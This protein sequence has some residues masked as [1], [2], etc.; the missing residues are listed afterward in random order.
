MKVVFIGGGSFRTLPVVRGA[1]AERKIFHRGEICL[2]DLDITRAEAMGRMIMKTPEFTGTEC[3]VTW[4]KSL[5]ASLEG[6][7]AVSVVLMASKPLSYSLG[8]FIS[9]K[10]ELLGS[11]NVSVNGAFLALKGGRLITGIARKM[12]KLCPKAWLMIFANPVAVLSGAV[13]NY[14]KIKA[15]GICE[16]FQNHMWDLTRLMGRNEHCNEYDVDVAGVNHCS[17]ILRGKYR[18]R[19]LYKELEKHIAGGLKDRNWNKSKLLHFALELMIEMYYRFGVMIFSNETDGFYHL[20]PERT[21]A[22]TAG[23]R[24]RAEILLDIEKNAGAR[25]KAN[26]DF[27]KMLAKDLDKKFW[28]NAARKH[29]NQFGRHAND[30][31]VE[32]LKALAGAG[33]RKLVFSRP[34][35]GAV[36]GFKDNTVLEYSQMLDQNGCTPVPNLTIPDAL[37][38]ITSALA[39]HQTLLGDAI[40]TEDPKDLYQ[41]LFAYPLAH[42][43]KAYWSLCR[44]LLKINK[45]EIAASFQKTAD[46]FK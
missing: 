27:V 46:Y 8:C 20:Y 34:N 3:K 24:T 5:E 22:L 18:G 11:D 36:A 41:A 44:E 43:S 37:H 1:L 26:A 19:D 45:D 39:T 6:A 16:G 15:M 13:N 14:T 4:G 28:D 35:R 10:Y 9:E 42:N 32:I 33:K 17:F 38:G 40:A 12:E 23:P 7:D 30:I 31:T 29:H 21:F 2:Y 25:E